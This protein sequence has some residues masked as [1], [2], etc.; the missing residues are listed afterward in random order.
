MTNFESTL[1]RLLNESVDAELGGRQP[2]PQP[3]LATAA[4]GGRTFRPWLVPLLAAAGV[5]AA[6]AAI[7]VPV[8][9]SADRPAG[10]PNNGG[11]AGSSTSPTHPAPVTAPD[12][13]GPPPAPLPPA[14]TPVE[15]GDAKLRLPVG[16][17]AREVA[18]P[19]QYG[20]SAYSREWCLAPAESADRPRP[21]CPLQFGPAAAVTT[22]GVPVNGNVPLGTRLGGKQS[23]CP[24]S[25]FSGS[26][27]G[28]LDR[29]G[30]RD[31]LFRE[32]HGDCPDSTLWIQQ[33]VVGTAPGYVLFSD[34]PTAERMAAMDEISR[35]ASLPAQ[36]GPLPLYDM[37]TVLAVTRHPGGYLMTITP[38]IREGG[39][40]MPSGATTRRYL[41]GQADLKYAAVGTRV[42]V[43]TDGTKVID[44][45][46][47][48][49]GW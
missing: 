39:D 29:F 36:T 10:G 23:S 6:I 48:I 26:T 3:R 33:Y 2:A 35:Y 22:S 12:P 41:I 38:I 37:G 19:H 42:G 1:K 30:Q 21:D 40:W 20:N 14:G 18:D 27:T 28:A 47:P 25:G 7:V 13:D 46:A 32:W 45:G 8:Q 17:V 31:A 43:T 34:Q 49:S 15:L 24:V 44:V 11:L 16:W 4:T 5:A 9:M